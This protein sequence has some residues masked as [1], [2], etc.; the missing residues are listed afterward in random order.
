MVI[1]RTRQRGDETNPNRFIEFESFKYIY[2]AL[3]LVV[4][5]L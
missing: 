5:K 3:K 2:D 4:G 1:L